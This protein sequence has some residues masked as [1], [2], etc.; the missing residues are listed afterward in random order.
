LAAV[1]AHSKLLM[2]EDL[3]IRTGTSRAQEDESRG[4]ILREVGD[5]VT[6]IEIALGQQASGTRKTSPLM[7]DRWKLNALGVRRVPDVLV[8]AHGEL[9]SGAIRQVQN[10]AMT[11]RGHL[12]RRYRL[13]FRN[14]NSAPFRL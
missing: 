11:F 13:C 14:V 12:I 9:L 8:F 2:S 7:A 10:H 3:K 6:G 1:L 4:T 5:G